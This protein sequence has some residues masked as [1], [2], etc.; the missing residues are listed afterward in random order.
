MTVIV[1]GTDDHDIAAAIEAA[2]H[3]VARVDVANREALDDAGIHEAVAFVL[4]EVQQATAIP[5]ARELNDD[6]RLVV[7]ADGSLPD[8]ARGQADLIVDPDLLDPAAVAEE[9]DA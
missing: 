4:T 7:Y 1:G 5:V 2:G 8:F 6:L 9:L 3:D